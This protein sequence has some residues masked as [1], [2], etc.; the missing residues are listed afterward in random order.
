MNLPH[1]S[2]VLRRLA[3]ETGEGTVGGDVG[4]LP[5]HAGRAATYPVL[6][7]RLPPPTD[8][9]HLARSGEALADPRAA[10]LLERL[11]ER[12]G[13]TYAIWRAPVSLPGVEVLHAGPDEA[14]DRLAFNADGTPDGRMWYLLRF[15]GTAPVHVARR[16]RGAPDQ[17]TALAYLAQ[18]DSTDTVWFLPGDRPAD[19]AGPRARA[20]RIVS[21]DGLAGEVEHDG[22][23]DVVIRRT[24]APGWTA[25]LNDG[26]PV[27]VARVDGGLQGVRVNGAGH[28][29][30][31]LR[32]Q[33]PHV[34]QASAV[35]AATLALVLLVLVR[36]VLALRAGGTSQS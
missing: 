36:G 3:E 27:P 31:S 2:P 23:C 14:L 18:D 7:M 16:A 24:Y 26:P 6:G 12:L 32:Y 19:V 15:A 5:V 25:R 13:M 35:S 33:P 9:L 4:N 11:L 30:I 10:R 20:A 34:W 22:A 21:W 17:R 29:R 28:T 1:D 8:G